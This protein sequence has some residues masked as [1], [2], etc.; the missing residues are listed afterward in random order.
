MSH[1]EEEFH[2]IEKERGWNKIFHVCL[3]DLQKK[4]FL[5]IQFLQKLTNDHGVQT[6]DKKTEIALLNINKGFNRFRDVLPCNDFMSK[7]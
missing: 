3:F 6:L 4:R 5:L 2:K 1:I 7:N